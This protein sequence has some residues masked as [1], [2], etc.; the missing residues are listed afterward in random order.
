MAKD[1]APATELVE[2]EAKS[3]GDVLAQAVAEGKAKPSMEP[4][5]TEGA[6]E[7]ID[8]GGG[9]TMVRW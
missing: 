1:K 7:V 9:T 2:V 4:T 5:N 3:S 6:K 8:L